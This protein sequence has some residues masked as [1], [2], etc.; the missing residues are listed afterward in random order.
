[1]LLRVPG[2]D[3]LAGRAVNEDKARM[4]LTFFANRLINRYGENPNLDYFHL[5]RELGASLP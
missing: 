2:Q 4:L 3:L 1:M 5:A